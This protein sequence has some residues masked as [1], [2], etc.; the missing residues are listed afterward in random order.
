MRQ[1]AVQGVKA[2]GDASALLN[3][4]VCPSKRPCVSFK[5]N[6]VLQNDQAAVRGVK[7]D[8]DASLRNKMFDIDDPTAWPPVRPATPTSLSLSLSLS[9]ALSLYQRDKVRG[10]EKVRPSLLP[11][12]PPSHNPSLHPSLRN[13]MFEIDDPT[14]WPQVCDSPNIRVQCD[15]KCI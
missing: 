9:R 5:T 4:C 8:G 13:K 1:A 3:D 7:A 11:S 6:Y 12:F 14:A 10:R 15:Q 2:D